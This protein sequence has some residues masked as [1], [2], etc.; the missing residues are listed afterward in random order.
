MALPLSK[1]VLWYITL[2]KFGG[3]FANNI[4]S[5]IAFPG[6]L[7]LCGMSPKASNDIVTVIGSFVVLY[8]GKVLVANLPTTV[9][10]ALP[11]LV[12]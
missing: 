5:G 7:G 6:L 12:Y 10:V 4:D 1:A 9:T 11:S 8:I 3:K 2:A